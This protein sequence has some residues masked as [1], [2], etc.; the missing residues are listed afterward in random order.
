MQKSISLNHIM[1]RAWVGLALALIVL[2][3]AGAAPAFAANY[4]VNNTGD[5]GD[6]NPG[7]NQCQTSGGNCTLRAAIMEAN[8]HAGADNITFNVGTATL[9]PF[10]EYPILTDDGTTIRGA[11]NITLDGTNVA[12]LAD[13]ITISASN[14]VIQGLR[15]H[16]FDTGL[17]IDGSAGVASNNLIGT[18]GDGN[19]DGQERNT[20]SGNSLAGLVI[21]GVDASGN[22][23]AGNRI[24]TN[25]SGGSAMPNMSGGIFISGGAHDNLIGTD[26]DGSGDGNERNIIS[27]NAPGAGIIIT[28]LGNDNT[29]A[30]NYIGVANNGSSALPNSTGI[31]IL[32]GSVQNLVG[33]FGNNPNDPNSRNV[34]S[35]NGDG[36]VIEGAGTVANWVAGNFIGTDDTGQ[37]AVP[38]TGSGISVED[39]ASQNF[40]GTASNSL[41]DGAERNVISGNGVNGIQIMNASD[42]VVAM[43]YIGVDATGDDALPNGTTFQPY[44]AGIAIVDSSFSNRIGTDGDGW[45]DNLEGNVIS[46]N[47]GA[48]IG[49]FGENNAVNGNIIAG[50]II[51]L[52]A[53]DSQPMGN[54]S[55]GILLAWVATGNHIGGDIAEEGNHI[56]YNGAAGVAMLGTG[57]DLPYGS[58]IRLNSIHDNTGL[59]IDLG[60]TSGSA[61]GPTPNDAGDGDSG[62]NFLMNTPVLTSGGTFAGVTTVEGEMID[63]MPDSAF[64]I[65]FYASESFDASGYGEG[66]IYVGS[67][68]TSTDSN[69]DSD[70]SV[71][72]DVPVNS[73]MWITA[74]A[75]HFMLNNSNT[76]EFSEAAPVFGEA[77]NLMSN[78]SF[79]TDNEPNNVP[80]GWTGKKL[81]ASDQMDCGLAHEGR[82]SFTMLGNGKGKSLMQSIAVDGSKGDSYDFSLW[83]KTQGADGSGNFQSKIVVTYSDGKKE[84]FSLNFTKGSYDWTLFSRSF[85]TRKAY[86]TITVEL[87][88]GKARGQVWFDE[89]VLAEA[90]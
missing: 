84:T 7:D 59:G 46:G 21:L 29:I 47:S 10:A 54:A 23:V 48:G 37:V 3:A 18:N 76:S 69:G 25:P 61:D 88:Y 33:T 19:N 12:S 44:N 60:N 31:H 20:I 38:N 1:R 6:A 51:G 78:A 2:L 79:E 13:G 77:L 86:H 24:G 83:V 27:G 72:L 58:V 63:A 82:C 5:L 17:T 50:N 53:T 9:L 49:L 66:E 43:N 39:A 28:G 81:T 30:G 90:P 35:G 80:D 65:H 45:V 75:T 52:D 62:P 8:A 74:T 87:L 67:G 85:T 89:V 42:N 71:V 57:A 11:D 14:C 56:A 34:I 70:F 73:G 64:M 40:I 15:I 41:M 22:V 4:T 68:I 16:N 32:A 26:A 55:Y 36:I